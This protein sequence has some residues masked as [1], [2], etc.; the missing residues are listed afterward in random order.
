MFNNW[1][2]GVLFKLRSNATQVLGGI[3]AATRR[4]EV[5]KQRMQI[6]SDRATGRITAQQ[7]TMQRG[8]LNLQNAEASLEANRARFAEREA[9]RLKSNLD[10]QR[11]NAMFVQGALATGGGMFIKDGLDQAARLQSAM[12]N[13]SI[14]TGVTGPGLDAM[15]AMVQQTSGA[16][17]QDAVTIAQE[18]AKAATGINDPKKLMAAFPQIAKFADVQFLQ[19]KQDPVEAVSIG[20][21]FAH[22]FKAY[23]GD[24]LNNMLDGLNKLSNMQPDGIGNALT[25]GRQFIPFANQLGVNMKDIFAYLAYMGQTGFLKGRGGTGFQNVLLNAVNAAAPTGTLSKAKVKARADLELKSFKFF[26]ANKNFRFQALVDELS[27]ER[28]RLSGKTGNDAQF[29][30][31]ITDLFGKEGGRFVAN[32]TD[33]LAQQQINSIRKTYARL[34]GVEAAWE[35]FSHTF[36]FDIKQFGT[37]FSNLIG[38]IFYPALDKIAPSILQLSDTLGDLTLWFN[39]HPNAGLGVAITAFAATGL[40]AA[41]AARNLWLLAAPFTMLNGAMSFLLSPM[42]WLWTAFAVLPPQVKLVVAALALIYLAFE[43][44][45]NGPNISAKINVWWA[46]HKG[47]IMYSVGYMLGE[48]MNAMMTGIKA[49]GDAFHNMPRTASGFIDWNKQELLWLEGKGKF[50]PKQING[51][52]GPGPDYLSAGYG[53]A[54]G[55]NRYG[56]SIDAQAQYDRAHTIPRVGPAPPNILEPVGGHGMVVN[57]GITMNVNV[58]PGTPENQVNHLKNELHNLSRNLIKNRSQALRSARVAGSTTHNLGFY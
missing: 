4:V 31:D 57:G 35:T 9:D 41:A 5:A 27:G 24:K 54:Q 19:N 30:K 18:L 48:I 32:V 26:D 22:L 14:K 37:N 42:R 38:A 46:A 53:D 25:Q 34:P 55:R 12:A 8:V 43:A 49:I 52:K 40:F 17:A 7:A 10:I 56:L 21:S 50:A 28:Q 29:I 3:E 6:S 16:T 15:R 45:T 23:S 44:F 11:R 1:V 58:A 13:I 36:L 51:K 33:K 2:I 39:A 20:T 47:H